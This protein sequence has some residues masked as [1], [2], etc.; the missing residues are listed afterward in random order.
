MSFHQY[1]SNVYNNCVEYKNTFYSDWQQGIPRSMDYKEFSHRKSNELT[2]DSPNMLTY[3]WCSGYIRKY[4]SGGR[5]SNKR[6]SK[7]KRQ[8]Q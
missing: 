2:W 3:N 7:R 4:S 6:Q 5:N 8:R 1:D